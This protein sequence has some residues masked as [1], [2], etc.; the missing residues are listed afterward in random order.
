MITNTRVL[1]FFEIL[2]WLKENDPTAYTNLDHKLKQIAGSE[3]SKVE[4]FFETVIDQAA[5][6][7]VDHNRF[8]RMIMDWYASHRTLITQAKDSTDPYSL[9][10]ETLNELIK[11]FGFPYPEL[12]A[13]TAKKSFFLT[14]LINLYQK[15]GTPEILV[16]V[17][18]TYFGL[19]NVVLSEWWIHKTAAGDFIAKAHPIYPEYYKHNTDYQLELPY[20]S[21][22][23]ED[24]LWHL[25]KPGNQT[26]AQLYQD[27]LISLPS[28]TTHITLQAALQIKSL[29]YTISILT[30]KLE[31]AYKHWINTGDLFRDISLNKFDGQFSFIELYLSIMYLFNSSNTNVGNKYAKYYTDQGDFAPLDK[32]LMGYG[33]THGEGFDIGHTHGG[34]Y[35]SDHTH[36]KGS[37]PQIE[38]LEVDGDGMDEVD[39]NMIIDEYN[40]L[41]RRPISKNERETLLGIRNQ[42]FTIAIDST[43]ISFIDIINNVPSY[44]ETISPDFKASIDELINAGVS[45]TELL[46]D[47]M[48]EFEGYINFHMEIF[49][50]NISFL[51]IGS[52]LAV[53]LEPVINFFK[54]FHVRL[55]DFLFFFSIDDPLLYSVL[56]ADRLIL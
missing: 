45:R 51:S 20:S 41:T 43:A 39:Y 42:K 36:G 14:D 8:K 48:L 15:K 40:N 46:Q 47:L 44:F 6:S 3:K 1:T 17:L 25:D 34:A 2:D 49:D 11:S 33:H 7:S 29:N 28:L 55:R 9:S 30:R 50:F 22:I 13:S 12:I 21:F 24:P 19:T 5:F 38:G 16:K 10:S 53:K 56:L 4:D 54:P 32:P 31:E 26:L 27:N 35:P 37:V 52:P 18:Q 23:S